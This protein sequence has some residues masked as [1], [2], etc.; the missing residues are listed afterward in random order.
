[1]AHAGRVAELCRRRPALLGEA[2]ERGDRHAVTTLSCL[3]LAHLAADNPEAAI[4][5]TRNA[6]A[7]W[8]YPGFHVQHFQCMS[9]LVDTH[10]YTG[11]VAAAQACL[12]EW[13]PAYSASLLYRI[14]R[15]RVDAYYARSRMLLG[16]AVNSTHPDPIL[17]AALRDAGRLERERVAWSAALARAVRAEAAVIRGDRRHAPSLLR[18]AATALDAADMAL[19]AAAARRR[20][21]ELAGGDEGRSAIAETD[22][23]MKSQGVQNPVRLTRMFFPTSRADLDASL[24]R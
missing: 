15:I 11:D 5:D 18:A 14:Q 7:G 22:A 21:G 4:L 9:D 24:S 20:M 13:W 23:A 12:S 10:L 3:A 19:H 17:Q 1:M 2:R 16:V 8:R 6:L